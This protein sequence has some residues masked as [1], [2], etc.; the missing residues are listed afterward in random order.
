MIKNVKNKIPRRVGIINNNLFIIYK[1][2][3]MTR[4]V[5]HNLL[6]D[7]IVVSIW[8]F[9]IDCSRLLYEY[10]YTSLGPYNIDSIKFYPVTLQKQAFDSFALSKLCF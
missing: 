9:Q 10:L 4:F 7:N 6:L 3:L 2:I 1:V 5:I 8:A